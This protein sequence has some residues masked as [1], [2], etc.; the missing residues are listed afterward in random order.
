VDVELGGEVIP[1]GEMVIVVLGSADRDPA[2]FS[3]P[4]RL[5]LG[6]TEN[7][8]VAF[9]RG[10]HYCLGARLEGAIALETLLRR[11]PGLR[12]AVRDGEL[13][14][15]PTPSFR[16]LVALPVAWDSSG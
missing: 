16:S 10:A 15:R 2:P 3:D 9:G 4:D 8:H 11:L 14:Y 12:L 5:D 13:A 1:R 6:R 7:R